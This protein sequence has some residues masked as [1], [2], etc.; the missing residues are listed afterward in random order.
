M[1]LKYA[2]TVL[3]L[4]TCLFVSCSGN[5]NRADRTAISQFEQDEAVRDSILAMLSKT[6]PAPFADAFA[7]LPDHAYTRYIRTEQFNDNEYLVAFRERT[8][9]YEGPA[10]QRRFTLLTADSSGTYDFGFFRQFVSTNVEEQDPGDLTPY[11]FPEDPSY[12]SPENY[13]AFLYRF[14]PDTLMRDVAASVIEVRARPVE[15]DGKNIRRAYYYFDQETDRLIAFQLERIDLTLFFREESLFF[16]HLQQAPDG[17]WLPYNT[18]FETR[19]IMPFKPP[20]RFRTV[21]TYSNIDATS[22]T[23][24]QWPLDV[25]HCMN[26]AICS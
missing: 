5:E 21:S 13:D 16:V 26:A 24:G 17:T 4:S 7:A 2:S 6:G 15:G 22:S 1:T 9:R 20:Q 10:G 18:R 12:L 3:I 23:I 14:R 8:V 19:I 25:G 11:L